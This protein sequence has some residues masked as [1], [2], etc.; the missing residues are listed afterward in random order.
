MSDL[1]S[2]EEETLAAVA[3][4]GTERDL[5]EV[6]VAAL[7]KKGRISDLMKG[8]G[9]MSPEER[10]EMGPAL[11]GLKTRVADAIAARKEE[12]HEAA[13]AERL[14]T[15]KV[16]ITLPVRPTPLEAGRIHP[17]SQTMDEIVAIFCDLGFAVEEGPDI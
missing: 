15:E 1:Q 11:N 8:L 16:D 4:A 5:E 3:G 9:K 10:Q 17:L 14:A 2:I 6:R 12:L 13:L 7:G